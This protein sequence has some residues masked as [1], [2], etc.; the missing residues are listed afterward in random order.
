M[1]LLTLDFGGT[2]VK[3]C[4]MNEQAEISGHGQLPAP[5]KS[6][7]DFIDLIC[8]LYRQY[9]DK[10]D[11]IAISMPGIIDSES[12]DIILVSVYPELSGTNLYELL[13]DHIPVPVSVENDGKAAI[14]AEAWKGALAG[15]DTAACVILGSGIGGGIIMDGKLQKGKGF[16]AG[17]ISDLMLYPGVYDLN[18]ALCFDA[19]TSGFLKAVAREKGMD[20]SLFE[21]SGNASLN[22][23]RIDG[24]EVMHWVEEGDAETLRVYEKLIQ[25]LAWLLINLKLIISPEKI[26]I[27]GGISRNERFI[28]DLKKEYEKAAAVFAADMPETFI[29]V[30]QFQADANLLGAVYHWLLMYQR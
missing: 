12:G 23:K 25:H 2:F 16:A 27:G 24:R 8:D 17:E 10:V 21:V 4:L 20:P 15:C 5:V 19:S 6:R 22:E 26:V 14:L 11:G 1:N 29:D 30:C 3:Y 18:N 7:D 9:E 28:S 13:K